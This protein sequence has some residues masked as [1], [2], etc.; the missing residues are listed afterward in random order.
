M[1]YLRSPAWPT[2]C[3]DRE[4]APTKFDVLIHRPEPAEP[5]RAQ[6][7]KHATNEADRRLAI[8][9]AL[10]SLRFLRMLYRKTP[11]LRADR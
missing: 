8:R 1:G 5:R 10:K 9:E 7:L 3:A 11:S 6:R 2:F 4:F